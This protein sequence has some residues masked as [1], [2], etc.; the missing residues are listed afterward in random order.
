MN[1]RTSQE[2]KRSKIFPGQ[3][4]KIESTKMQSQIRVRCQSVYQHLI[5]NFGM[6]EM[7]LSKGLSSRDTRSVDDEDDSPANRK[8]LFGY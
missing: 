2:E 3:I 5:K 8:L 7:S 1:A 4:E 6:R